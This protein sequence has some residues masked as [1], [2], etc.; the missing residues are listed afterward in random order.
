MS[1]QPLISVVLAVRNEIE[2]LGAA[3]ESLAAQSCDGIDIEII[4]VDGMSTDGSRSVAED[5]CARHANARMVE[6][7]MQT[8]PHAFNTG[9]QQASGEYV[10]ILGS[11]ACYDTRYLQTCFE[12]LLEK[13]AVGCS[14]R[15]QITTASQNYESRVLALLMSLPFTCSSQSFRNIKEGYA[16]TI[17]YGVF[18]K[19]ALIDVGLYNTAL[20]RNQDN[21]MNRRLIEAGHK[22]FI[23]WK[24]EAVY[25]PKL[26]VKDSMFYAFRNGHWNVFTL[27]HNRR[28][29]R[30]YHWVPLFFVMA[31][32]SLLLG[33]VICFLAGMHA[34]ASGF[35]TALLI[36]LLVHQACGL[37]SYTHYRLKSSRGEQAV[38]L[39]YLFL[40]PLTLAF[41]ASYGLG[42]LYG[43]LT[44]RWRAGSTA[45][46]PS[47]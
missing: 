37:M 13:K 34:L 23:T 28:A 26:T 41:H 32:L 9:I 29:L 14:G 12:V 17:P 33:S 10:A 42:S 1:A 45:A 16:T 35:F 46:R 22:L 11:H 21:D 24:A 47:R 25:A 20:T 30:W 31:L 2:H 3:L 40:P 27:G 6:N 39:A 38:R 7:P 18:K 5:F 8:A 44:G 36:L 19:Q 15:V 43:L 4:I